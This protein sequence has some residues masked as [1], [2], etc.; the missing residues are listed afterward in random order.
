MSPSGTRAVASFIICVDVSVGAGW[1]C[2][3]GMH[4][5]E[6]SLSL[7][8]RSSP[9][10]LVLIPQTV[11]FLKGKKANYKEQEEREVGK[12]NRTQDALRQGED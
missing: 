4:S 10:I 8:Y 11:L 5:L 12:V 1:W 6:I 7:L 9:W 3:L 2:Q